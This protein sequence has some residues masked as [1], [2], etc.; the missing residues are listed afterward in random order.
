MTNRLAAYWS[1]QS[2][3]TDVPTELS[4][5]DGPA[6]I[7]IDAAATSPRIYSFNEWAPR[8]RAARAAARRC[9]CR[10]LPTRCSVC[11]ERAERS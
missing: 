3:C 7:R 6:T 2:S 11:R 5:A 4:A 1:K 9:P 8:V 10:S